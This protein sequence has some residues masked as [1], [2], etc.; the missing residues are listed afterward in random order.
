ME[1]FL[2]VKKAQLSGINP[3][4]QKALK[5]INPIEAKVILHS[6]KDDHLQEWKNMLADTAM[7]G[8][9]AKFNQNKD[10][11]DY[12]CETEPLL[13]GEASQNMTWGTSIPLE[14]DS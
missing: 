11:A 8:L 12:L 13:L 1:Q 3:T 4:I 10:L 5:A 2:A 9:K 7:E 14:D 6:L